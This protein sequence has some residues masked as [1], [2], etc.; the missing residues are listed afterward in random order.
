MRLC[1]VCSKSFYS[2]HTSWWLDRWFPKLILSSTFSLEWG[3][4][5]AGGE[6]FLR[7]LI[8]N[9]FKIFAIICNDTEVIYFQYGQHLRGAIRPSPIKLN[10]LF[11]LSLK[12]ILSHTLWKN[13]PFLI[14]FIHPLH[15]IWIISDT[16]AIWPCK[17]DTFNITTT[18]T[19]PHSISLA[20]ISKYAICKQW[21]YWDSTQNLYSSDLPLGY[22][23]PREV[24]SPSL[25]YTYE[26]HLIW[27]ACVAFFSFPILCMRS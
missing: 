10:F 7:N 17:K 4:R 14:I 3:D 18:T 27:P 19:F 23:R 21:V 9:I 11:V 1:F 15:I 6:D 5:E 20:H 25:Y 13:N 16:H 12:S 24:F 26:S 2:L 8:C 22:R